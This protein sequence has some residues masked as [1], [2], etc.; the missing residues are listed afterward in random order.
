MDFTNRRRSSGLLRWVVALVIFVVSATNVNSFTSGFAA[1]SLNFNLHPSKDINALSTV[2]LVKRRIMSITFVDKREVSVKVMVC[3]CGPSA[4]NSNDT[5]ACKNINSFV[6]E[7]Y[8]GFMPAIAAKIIKT[9]IN[10]LKKNDQ[11][12]PM[13]T[14]K[15]ANINEELTEIGKRMMVKNDMMMYDSRACEMISACTFNTSLTK[16]NNIWTH[17]NYYPFVLPVP[18][19]IDIGQLKSLAKQHGKLVYNKISGRR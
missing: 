12:N 14:T 8:N 2:S 19:E 9:N 16:D 15:A 11:T 7:H 10:V 6:K 18:D 5:I 17:L 3:K 13:C 4:N 1:N